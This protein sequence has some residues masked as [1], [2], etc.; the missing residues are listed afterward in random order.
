MHYI[1]PTQPY[2]HLPTYIYTCIYTHTWS[3]CTDLQIHAGYV[4]QFNIHV[5]CVC[6]CVIYIHVCVCVCISCFFRYT[7]LCKYNGD[8]NR[9]AI[10]C[11]F[12]LWSPVVLF[13]LL[14]DIA[15]TAIC[16]VP[17]INNTGSSDGGW[18][19]GGEEETWV[20]V[21]VV[22]RYTV[23]K[24]THKFKLVQ[25]INL[26]IW[27]TKIISRLRLDIPGDSTLHYGWY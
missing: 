23:E 6:R 8:A 4:L 21:C 9:Y 5:C 26:K 15:N 16:K 20:S 1:I 14:T 25:E 22:V 2:Y 17:V 12:L 24:L 27:W 18:G 3:Q 10:S 13:F 7:L 11:N 19:T